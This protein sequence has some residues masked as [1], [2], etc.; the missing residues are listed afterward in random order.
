MTPDSDI[1]LLLVTHSAATAR[2]DWIRAQEALRGL[3]RPFDIILISRA[4]FEETKN[5]IGGIA[6]P[7]N[8][9]GK[10]VYEAA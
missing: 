3:G 2:E 7:A 10:V 4:R 1:D 8:M 9:Q 6:Y 5:V